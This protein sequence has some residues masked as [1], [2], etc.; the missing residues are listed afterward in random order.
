LEITTRDLVQEVEEDDAEYEKEAAKLK[1]DTFEDAKALMDKIEKKR[2]AK[3]AAAL[4]VS[5][6]K[7]VNRDIKPKVSGN[8]NNEKTVTSPANTENAVPQTR[9]WSQW[10]SSWWY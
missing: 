3:E 7:R 8:N 9:T 5:T 6:E 2:R 10:M 1:I 4:D